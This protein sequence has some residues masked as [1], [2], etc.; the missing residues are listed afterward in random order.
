MNLSVQPRAVIF[1]VDSA[2][3]RYLQGA[4]RNTL[5]RLAVMDVNKSGDRVRPPLR[6]LG[7]G[8]Q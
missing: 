3:S 5:Q 8:G 2:R 7:V 6:K 4:A 1:R